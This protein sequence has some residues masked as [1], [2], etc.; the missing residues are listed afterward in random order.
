MKIVLIIV[1]VL[2]ALY[3]LAQVLQLLGIIGAGFSL[4]GVGLAVLSGAVAL[5]CFKKAFS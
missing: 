2:A 5:I 4:P 1:G 3:C